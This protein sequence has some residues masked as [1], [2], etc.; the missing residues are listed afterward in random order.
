MNAELFTRIVVSIVTIVMSLIGAY[1]IPLI[2]AKIGEVEMNKLLDFALKCVKWANQTIPKEEW[3]RK[4]AEV[5]DKVIDFMDKNLKISLSVEQVDAIIEA[6]VIDCKD[7][8][9]TTT[10]K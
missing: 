10:K 8:K 2:K 9:K 4:K 3:E 7:T 1:V 5:M 6:F